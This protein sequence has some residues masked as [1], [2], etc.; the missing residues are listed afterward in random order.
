[1]TI[2]KWKTMRHSGVAFPPEYR[3]HGLTVRIKGQPVALEP[4][5]EEMLMAW[6]N[7]IGTPYVDDPVFQKNFCLSLQGQWPDVFAGIEI[8]DIDWDELQSIAFAQKLANMPEEERKRVSA[9]RKKTREELKAK[10]GAAEVDEIKVEVAAY[11]VEPPGIFM[12]RGAHPKRGTWKPRVEPEQVELNLGDEVPLPEAPEGHDWKGKVT[13]HDGLWIARWKDELSDKVKYV[14][15]S[16][17][18]HLR[19]ER[20]KLKFVKA[21]KLEASLERVRAR[22]RKGMRSRKESERQVATVA[23]LI[24][25][26]AMRVGDEK[27]EDEADTV[28]ASTLRK[29][30]VQIQEHQIEFDFLGKDSV[31]WEK[32]L[33]TTGED[34]VLADNLREFM[35]GKKPEDQ[36]FPA[37]RSS[38]VNRFLSSAMPGLSAKVF[39]TYAATTVVKTFLEKQ[40]DLSEGSPD[41]EKEYVA[42]RAN[43]EAAIR[44]NHKRTPPKTWEESI[45]KKEETLAKLQV[46][47]P[48]T[49]KQRERLKERVEKAQRALD[50]AKETRDYNLNTS[51]KNYIDPRVYKAW[52]EAVGFDWSKLYTQALQRKFSWARQS[53]L[54]WGSLTGKSLARLAD[55]NGGQDETPVGG[56]VQEEPQAQTRAPGPAPVESKEEAREA[57]KEEAKG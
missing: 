38:T 20:E 40:K 10:Y 17:T 50:L 2:A 21:G 32:F 34:Q 47:E 12:G 6:A 33:P 45:R 41:A 35:E 37:I 54:K 8:K 22:I 15:L 24:D 57:V 30:H 51:L 18:S 9:E 14:W 26:L 19:Q 3:P 4:L 29:E 42:R 27:D 49:D 36:I 56:L 31:R 55:D 25:K 23:Y 16:E 53:R 11:L 43:L 39:R 5:Q 46:Q 7:K 13:D 28:G 1:M 52:G 44:C 48:K